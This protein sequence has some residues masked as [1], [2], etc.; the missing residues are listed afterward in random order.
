MKN[1]VGYNKKSDIVSNL[2]SLEVL[3]KEECECDLS[4]AINSAYIDYRSEYDPKFPR[5]PYLHI[6]G[7][8]EGVYNPTSQSNK[9]ND[10]YFIE[11]DDEARLPVDVFYEFDDEELA[12]LAKKGMYRRNFREPD[13]FDRDTLTVHSLCDI[14]S[15]DIK[16]D[17]DLLFVNLKNPKNL[18]TTGEL[19][20]YYFAREFSDVIA[21]APLLDTVEK[22]SEKEDLRRYDYQNYDELTAEE[23][24]V[25]EEQVDDSLKAYES[26]VSDV[27]KQLNID[28]NV[29]DVIFE[30]LINIAMKN[31]NLTREQAEEQLK[32]KLENVNDNFEDDFELDGENDGQSEAQSDGQKSQEEE[33]KEDLDKVGIEN[34]ER[35]MFEKEVEDVKNMN[36][37]DANAYTGVDNESLDKVLTELNLQDDMLSKDESK[38][39]SEGEKPQEKSQEEKHEERDFPS[40][41]AMNYGNEYGEVE[42][43]EQ[44]EPDLF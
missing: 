30:G 21:K 23:E 7:K 18:E 4:I 10:I 1:T 32:E 19:C 16:G 11:F 28:E 22:T 44:V 15:Y 39:E 17:N 41:N 34:N 2:R 40:D 24:K 3:G 35:Q 27:M 6:K 36:S 43:D 5:R 20:N 33:Q 8:C 37:Y 12:L 42:I 26:E 9:F 14:T 25:T 13:I 29:Q 31:N 38:S